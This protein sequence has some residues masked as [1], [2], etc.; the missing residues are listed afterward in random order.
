VP[1]ESNGFKGELGMLAPAL[2]SVVFLRKTG[3]NS[4]F[5]EK[6]LLLVADF[7]GGLERNPGIGPNAQ[8]LP[9]SVLCGRE[10]VPPEPILA[11]SGI[12]LEEQA[13]AV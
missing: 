3:V 9:A 11:A 1:V 2:I 8:I 13:G 12:D 4:D 10:A 7:A 5:I 6:S